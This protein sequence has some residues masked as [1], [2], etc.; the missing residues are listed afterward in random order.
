MS[1]YEL[2]RARENDTAPSHVK[3]RK[4][5]REREGERGKGGD[6]SE[7]LVSLLYAERGQS[8]RA[9]LLPAATSCARISRLEYPAAGREAR[10]RARQRGKPTGPSGGTETAHGAVRVPCHGADGD[11]RLASREGKGDKR[12]SRKPGTARRR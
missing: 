9:A 6:R 2:A 3:R 4:G 7:S 5:K 8:R 1:N 11:G 12:T 10:T